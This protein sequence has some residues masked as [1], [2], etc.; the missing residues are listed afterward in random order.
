MLFLFHYSQRI[1][2]A[3]LHNERV[4][5]YLSP[6]V[7]P[8]FFSSRLLLF[9]S[10][11]AVSSKLEARISELHSTPTATQAPEGANARQNL[12]DLGDLLAHDATKFHFLFDSGDVS[13]KARH[14]EKVRVSCTL[15][16]MQTHPTKLMHNLPHTIT[17]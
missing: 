5:H 8:S 14:S 13:G 17:W 1:F 3:Y 16:H 11:A 4:T 12:L 10:A 6:V 9:R 2:L 15:L 7:A